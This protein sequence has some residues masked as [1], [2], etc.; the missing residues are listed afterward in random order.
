[1]LRLDINL[2]FSVINILILYLGCK[3]FLFKPV[4]AIIAKRQEEID[5]GFAEADRAKAEAEEIRSKQDAIIAAANEESHR[6]VSEAKTKAKAERNRIIER[7]KEDADRVMAQAQLEI[8]ADRK[9]TMKAMEHQI[10]D[11]VMTATEK[12][13]G[14]KRDA[15][16]DMAMYDKFLAE[17]GDGYD[18]DDN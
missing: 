4:N 6:I 14:E 15:A 5:A 12:I 11:L 10:A 9:R 17:V 7:A 2:L 8:E 3:K 16:K 13:V 1:M 18:A